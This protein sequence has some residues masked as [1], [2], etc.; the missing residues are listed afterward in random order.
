MNHQPLHLSISSGGRVQSVSVQRCI[1]PARPDPSSRETFRHD[2]PS[3]GSAH[4]TAQTASRFITRCAAASCCSSQPWDAPPLTRQEFARERPPAPPP[5]VGATGTARRYSPAHAFTHRVLGRLR[6]G[7][8]RSRR[9]RPGKPMQRYGN[10]QGHTA[11]DAA[12]RG[13]LDAGEKCFQ[14]T[15][16]VGDLPPW[17]RPLAQCQP[18]LTHAPDY[19][20]TLRRR[21]CLASSEPRSSGRLARA[22]RTRSA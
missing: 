9:G 1:G 12:L 8:A 20:M 22:A 13:R 14:A 16:V 2:A 21:H 6:V 3:V 15:D 10:A 18:T 7:G 5:S 4:D 11:F 17:H 19:Q